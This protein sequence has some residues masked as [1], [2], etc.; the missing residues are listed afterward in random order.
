MSFNFNIG[1]IKVTYQTSGGAVKEKLVFDRI[2]FNYI[3][4]HYTIVDATQTK[5]KTEA[6]YA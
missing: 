6:Q 5:V 3:E 1:A 2:N 4:L